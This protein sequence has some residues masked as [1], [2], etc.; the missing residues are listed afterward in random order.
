MANV[1]GGEKAYSIAHSRSISAKRANSEDP[2]E[3]TKNTNECDK[4]R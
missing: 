3:T 1:N 2:S 4:K